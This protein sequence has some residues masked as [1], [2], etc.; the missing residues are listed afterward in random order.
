MVHGDTVGARPTIIYAVRGVLHFSIPDGDPQ[1]SLQ[2]V[3][4]EL[5]GTG[6]MATL[7]Y[8]DEE[9]VDDR[10]MFF[11]DGGEIDVYVEGDDGTLR[12]TDGPARGVDGAD[13]R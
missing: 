3:L 1:L 12:Q 6:G 13:G 10:A 5:Q 11:W 7:R 2:E 4:A 8:L 9:E